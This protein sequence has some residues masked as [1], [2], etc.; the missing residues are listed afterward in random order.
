MRMRTI[1]K[2]SAVY[3]GAFLPLAYAAGILAV[4]IHEVLGHGFAAIFAGGRLHYVVIGWD[5]MGYAFTELQRDCPVV[6]QM[7]HLA[8]GSLATTVVGVPVFL[9]GVRIATPSRWK[10]PLIVVGSIIALDGLTYLF[11][12]SVFPRPP[13][14]FGRFLEIWRQSSLPGQAA[15]HAAMVT[16]GGAGTVAVLF[17]ASAS[18]HDTIAHRLSAGAIASVALSVYILVVFL[19]LPAILLSYLFDWDQLISGVGH[20]PNHVIV[21][22]TIVCACAV[23]SLRHGVKLRAADE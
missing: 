18:V 21:A 7:L 10:L 4:V 6:L 22:S 11:F 14:D 2:L 17:L 16:L 8:S 23:L 20:F 9:A 1:A 13:G 15:G 3:L 12:N 5:G 19:I